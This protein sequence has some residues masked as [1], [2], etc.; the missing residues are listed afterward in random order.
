MRGKIC[1]ITNIEDAI[2]AAD[3]GAWALGFNFYLG[4]KRYITPQN[5][6]QIIKQLPKSVLK[7][8]IF[9]GESYQFIAQNID[10]IGLDFAQIYQDFDVSLTDKKSLILTLQID[11]KR[12]LPESAILKSYPYIL[13]DAPIA[14]DGLMGGTGRKANW[15]LAAELA[16]DYPLILAGGLN[17]Q[18]VKQA[19]KIVR[20][21][22]LDVASGVEKSY[23]IKDHLLVKNFLN[24]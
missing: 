19:I 11:S 9:I 10:D 20:P 14:K 13:F 17:C 6:K 18:N 1:G 2:F 16:A 24:S 12:Q 22:A 23:G 21:Y 7:I 5:V 15:D 3:N 4:S 8:G